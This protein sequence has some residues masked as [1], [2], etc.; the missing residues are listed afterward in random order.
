MVRFFG[1][2][3]CL[4]LLV[5]LTLDMYG[6][7]RAFAQSTPPTLASAAEPGTEEEWEEPHPLVL[8]GPI[9]GVFMLTGL[10][11]FFY[12]IYR[13]Y[14]EPGQ[15]CDE[16]GRPN[17]PNGHSPGGARYFLLGFYDMRCWL[18][19]I[20]S[21]WDKGLLSITKEKEERITRWVFRPTQADLPENCSSGETWLWQKH[22]AGKEEVRISFTEVSRDFFFWDVVEAH[23][24]LLKKIYRPRYFSFR[25]LSLIITLTLIIGVGVASIALAEASLLILIFPLWIANLLI[26]WIYR[27]KLLR[28]SP[29]GQKLFQDL[30]G[31]KMSYPLL[32]DT[33]PAT[34]DGSGFSFG[35]SVALEEELG[36]WADLA[37]QADYAWN[38]KAIRNRDMETYYQAQKGY[39]REQAGKILPSQLGLRWQRK[40]P[41]A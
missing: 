12:R 35:W 5:G 19:D 25:V 18:G 16:A 4:C 24:R 40:N 41:P 29:E 21:L 39:A 26:P 14:P 9:I 27:K 22:F 33:P 20:G 31:F 13:D 30:Y 28:Y 10:F 37:L 36:W 11:V 34:P 32:P 6:Q 8:Y 15:W 38:L 1:V 7:S 23:E 2:F 17:P 3:L